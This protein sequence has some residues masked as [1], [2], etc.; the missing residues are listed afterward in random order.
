MSIRLKISVN[1]NPYSSHGMSSLTRSARPTAV[2]VGRCLCVVRSAGVSGW[3]LIETA[4]LDRASPWLL[5]VCLDV[6]FASVGAESYKN[7]ETVSSKYKEEAS[8]L[9]TYC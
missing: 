2:A 8:K 4:D 9:G 5:S 7:M 3:A 6:E 1:A